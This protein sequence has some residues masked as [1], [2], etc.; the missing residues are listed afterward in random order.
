MVNSNTVKAVLILLLSL[1]QLGCA[2]GPLGARKDKFDPPEPVMSHV[3]HQDNGAI[4]Q[5]GM[6]IGLFDRV[7][8]RSVGDIVTIVLKENTN[9]SATANTNATKDQKV[10]LQAPT[11]AGS[12]VTNNGKEVLKNN[13]DAG[14]EFSGQGTSAQSSTLA[15]HITVTV[16]QVQVNGNLVVIGQKMMMLNQSSEFIRLSGIIRPQD[17]R[18]DNTV[19]S[20]RVADVKLA[21]SGDGALSSANTMGPL[22][23]FF[24]SGIWPY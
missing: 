15:G 3:P 13:I 20:Y 18:P 23:R 6:A 12:E 5:Q 21:Y 9:A 24:Q 8:A 19:E 17:I 10:D 22:A 7:T 16:S 4:Y 11:L 1:V 14:R 2:F